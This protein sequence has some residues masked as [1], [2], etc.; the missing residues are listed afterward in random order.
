MVVV[1]VK[2]RQ[3]EYNQNNGDDQVGKIRT[4]AGNGEVMGENIIAAEAGPELG[5][6][7]G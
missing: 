6:Q 5:Q 2:E 7:G 4:L 3:E 1:A